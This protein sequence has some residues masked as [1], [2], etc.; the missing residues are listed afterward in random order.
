[1]ELQNQNRSLMPMLKKVMSVVLAVIMIMSTS[2][3][4]LTSFAMEDGVVSAEDYFE[5]SI[6]D[7]TAVITRYNGAGPDVIIPEILDG[8]RVERIEYGAFY[9]IDTLRSVTIPA[10]IKDADMAFSYCENLENIYVDQNNETYVSVDG[11]LFTKDM[12]DLVTYPGAGAAEYEIPYGVVNICYDAFAG[13]SIAQVAIPDT[14]EVIGAH[15]FEGC[16]SLKYINLPETI[17]VIDGFA[18]QRCTSLKSISIPNFVEEISFS[19]FEL[20][21][22]LE[23]IEMP[24]NLK[25]I[26]ESA[27]EDCCSLKEI[28]LPSGVLRIEK[29]AFW[30][31]D[32]LTKVVVPKSTEIDN[33]FWGNVN[34]V[35]IS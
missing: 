10:S 6:E 20:C 8:Y 30:G 31:C 24:L 11:V 9:N 21:T 2:S 4:A 18:F 7:D 16:E 19:S 1:M 25:S 35:K 12:K 28:E 13:S 22:D 26:E 14:V 34:I 29:R 5:Y 15:A 32:S 17:K 3:I 33:A 27:F 23:F